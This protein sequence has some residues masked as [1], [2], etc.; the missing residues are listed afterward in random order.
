M[1][2]P[3]LHA[4]KMLMGDPVCRSARGVRQKCATWE[5]RN[6]I[7]AG[8]A[9]WTCHSMDDDNAKFTYPNGKNI[10]YIRGGKSLREWKRTYVKLIGNKGVKKIHAYGRTVGKQRAFQ[11]HA[12]NMF[13]D[14]TF[15][16]R[17]SLWFMPRLIRFVS[18]SLTATEY[19]TPQDKRKV[20]PRCHMRQLLTLWRGLQ[21]VQPIIDAVLSARSS[22]FALPT[23]PVSTHSSNFTGLD[24]FFVRAPRKWWTEKGPKNARSMKSTWGHPKF[25][26]PQLAAR[27]CLAGMNS[28]WVCASGRRQ[29]RWQPGCYHKTAGD[30]CAFLPSQWAYPPE[31]AAHVWVQLTKCS[32]CCC[33]KGFLHM[34]NSNKLIVDHSPV[35]AG[36]FAN[37][38]EPVF[39]SRWP[40][41]TYLCP[42]AQLTPREGMQPK[43]PLTLSSAQD[44]HDYGTTSAHF[45]LCKPY[46]HDANVV[47]EASSCQEQAV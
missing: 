24:L 31:C 13:L 39:R 10:T 18:Y 40:S 42:P 38:V 32:T 22:V 12:E 14:P 43:S 4:L 16:Q 3:L 35:C 6:T 15:T 21:Y 11:L 26:Y 2:K 1:E 7:L 29:K 46:L 30:P 23:L 47:H 20:G 44:F 17:L 41:L 25:K 27:K 9:N 36:W 45:S 33:K 5:A 34:P 28:R 19:T 37:L 8:F